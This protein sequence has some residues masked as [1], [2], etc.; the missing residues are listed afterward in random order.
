MPRF[1]MVTEATR[2]PSRAVEWCVAPDA[3]AHAAPALEL[4]PGAADVNRARYALRQQPCFSELIQNLDSTAAVRY[5]TPELPLT[6][7]VDPAVCRRS[8]A[9]QRPHRDSL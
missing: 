1:M 9:F 7:A 2:C 8:G 4:V 3:S 5:K 6:R